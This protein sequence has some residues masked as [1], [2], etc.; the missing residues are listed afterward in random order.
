MNKLRR[1]LSMGFHNSPSKSADTIDYSESSSSTSH[2][3]S[4]SLSKN[5]YSSS[6]SDSDEEPIPVSK[7]PLNKHPYGSPNLKSLLSPRAANEKTLLWYY[8]TPCESGAYSS[9]RTSTKRKSTL[10]RTKS[11]E[12]PFQ[13]LSHSYNTFISLSFLYSVF[14]NDFFAICYSNLFFIPLSTSFLQLFSQSFFLLFLIF[15]F[16]IIGNNDL[17]IVLIQSNLCR[18]EPRRVDSLFN[19]K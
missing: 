3:G 12:F 10:H 5:A 1:T 15:L 16:H 14:L 18:V 4:Q 13:W 17:V 19:Y 7:L 8:F 11:P 6:E 9:P 2:S